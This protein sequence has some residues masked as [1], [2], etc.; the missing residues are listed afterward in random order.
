MINS[1]EGKSWA[2]MIE[3]MSSAQTNLRRTKWEQW[4]LLNSYLITR[5][6]YTRFR[7]PFNTLLADASFEWGSIRSLIARINHS[8]TSKLTDHYHLENIR[9]YISFDL[10]CVWC[11]CIII[12]KS[13]LKPVCSKKSASRDFSFYLWFYRF[14]TCQQY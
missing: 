8:H 6:L 2:G 11:F 9:V 7:D 1:H 5:S 13:V 12:Y 14:L 10:F 4:S 3:E